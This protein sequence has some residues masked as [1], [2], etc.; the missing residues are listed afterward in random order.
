M[1][2]SQKSDIELAFTNSSF[3]I[4][5]DKNKSKNKN[6]SKSKN[7]NK[8]KKSAKTD[9]F[10]TSLN[11]YDKHALASNPEF[12]FE[13]KFYFDA[14]KIGTLHQ[15]VICRI[16][17]YTIL[18]KYY[19]GQAN[20]AVPLSEIS[21][22]LVI[23]R[24]RKPI[25][26]IPKL[27]SRPSNQECIRTWF[28]TKQKIVIWWNSIFSCNTKLDIPRY[29]KQKR[30]SNRNVLDLKSIY[31][32]LLQNQYDIHDIHDIHDIYL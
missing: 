17:G 6:K 19:N 11:L 22:I 32:C 30:K 29:P 18:F 1:I 21:K 4:K 7:K 8:N 23:L 27:C 2:K 24:S 12:A 3:F 10:D 13:H 28:V 25:P 9:I 26:I 14:E 31:R 20:R 15:N 5:Y 16:L